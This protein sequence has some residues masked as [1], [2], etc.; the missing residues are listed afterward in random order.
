MTVCYRNYGAI[1][2]DYYGYNVSVIELR[3][4]LFS[5]GNN[6]LHLVNK[7]MDLYKQDRHTLCFMTVW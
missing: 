1:A 5:D 6:M 7:Y 3:N 4:P 2:K